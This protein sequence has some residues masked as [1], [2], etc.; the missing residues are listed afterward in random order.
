MQYPSTNRTDSFSQFMNF[1]AQTT[2]SLSEYPSLH[3]PAQAALLYVT[4]S[5][6]TRLA[7]SHWQ[8]E[9][10]KSLFQAITANGGFL[11][12]APQNK[13][14]ALFGQNQRNS[15]AYQAVS[16][17]LA[18]IDQIGTVNEV[19][20]AAGSPLLR[21][22]IGISTGLVSLQQEDD[23]LKLANKTGFQ[24]LETARQLSELNHQA[25]FPAAFISQETFATL[26]TGSEWHIESLGPVWLP[27]HNEGQVV[28]AVMRPI[29]LQ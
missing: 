29:C 10:S 5:S 19:R 20:L 28:H 18:L 8:N 4:I 9:Y 14:A 17:A 23:G 2:M 11:L 24:L 12:N 1:Q 15:P 22:G 26:V 27:D 21:L 25:P 7:G 13:I 16:T 3:K 6:P